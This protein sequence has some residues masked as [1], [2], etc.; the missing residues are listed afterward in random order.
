V[1]VKIAAENYIVSML[2]EFHIDKNEASVTDS[3]IKLLIDEHR[4]HLRPSFV[5]R[6]KQFHWLQ[7]ETP[8]LSRA[9]ASINQGQTQNSNA[10]QSDLLISFDDLDHVPAEK[11]STPGNTA[12]QSDLIP[13]DMTAFIG[14][15]LAK[16][17]PHHVSNAKMIQWL[18]AVMHVDSH[19]FELM[20]DC[21]HCNWCT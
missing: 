4:A 5:N 2:N 6:L 1:S 20:L 8:A 19:V 17:L 14:N 11:P 15:Y 7:M 12:E 18:T 10:A 21:K 16:Q 3:M 9:A 13:S